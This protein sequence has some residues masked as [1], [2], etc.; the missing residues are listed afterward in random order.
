MGSAIGRP[1]YLA[2]YSNAINLLRGIK[3]DWQAKGTL[4][5]DHEFKGSEKIVVQ[6]TA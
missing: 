6:N 3:A 2:E 4:E 5:I 1:I